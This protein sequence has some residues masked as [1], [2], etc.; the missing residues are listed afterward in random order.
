LRL[1]DSNDV[2]KTCVRKGATGEVIIVFHCFF[3]FLININRNAVLQRKWMEIAM[4]LPIDTGQ[5]CLFSY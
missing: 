4:L 3:D 2:G 5:L 1:A